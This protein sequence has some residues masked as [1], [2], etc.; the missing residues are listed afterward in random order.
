MVPNGDRLSCL[1]QLGMMVA[2]SFLAALI[3]G[4][5]ESFRSRRWKDFRFVDRFEDDSAVQEVAEDR[6]RWWQVVLAIVI[7]IPMAI[8]LVPVM[9]GA[10]PAMFI[11]VM[12]ARLMWF[13]RAVRRHLRRRGVILSW[14]I[15]FAV[16]PVLL[17]QRAGRY[18]SGLSLTEAQ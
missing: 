13:R 16:A 18:I 17:I 11:S 14:L 6:V 10:I 8:I 9:I 1:E 3:L 15:S 4:T 5:I 2:C 7:G 12:L